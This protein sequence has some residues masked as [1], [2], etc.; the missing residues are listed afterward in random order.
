MYHLYSSEL[1]AMY[2]TSC[3]HSL[4]FGLECFSLDWSE[5]G[6]GELK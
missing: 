3:F 6:L 4:L 5:H 1:Y 2:N